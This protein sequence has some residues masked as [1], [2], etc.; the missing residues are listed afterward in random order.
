MA[1]DGL[2][3]VAECEAELK[4]V[5]ELIAKYKNTPTVMR[6]GPVSAN[7]QSRLNQLYKDREYWEQRYEEAK[8]RE[9]QASSLQGP[10]IKVT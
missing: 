7:F 2:Y 3:T 5:N 10:D 8:A 6:D 4:R 1:E 9:N